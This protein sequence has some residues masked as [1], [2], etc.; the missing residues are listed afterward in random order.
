MRAGIGGA[1]R[2]RSHAREDHGSNG[3]QLGSEA[4]PGVGTITRPGLPLP[5]GEPGDAAAPDLGLR[6]V[7]D[8]V[9]APEP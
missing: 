7:A 9:V 6:C 8:P 4:G 3:D 5:P 2:A 1:G